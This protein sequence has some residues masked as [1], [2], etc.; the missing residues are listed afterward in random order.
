LLGAAKLNLAE[1]LRAEEASKPQKFSIY[2]T[3]R[4]GNN[5]PIEIGH[6]LDRAVR[7]MTR[8]NGGCT[9]MP[10]AKGA[11]KHRGT[12][13]LIVEDTI[14]IYSYLFDPEKFVTDFH[15]IVEL[16]HDYGYETKQDAV[17]AE[18]SGWSEEDQSYVS[19]AYLIPSE[20]YLRHQS[21]S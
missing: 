20:N 8:I 5:N 3:D 15:Y 19:E 14:V 7:V 13:K 2:I 16:L 18:F 9:R 21:P 4:D 17:I 10:A 12:R 11:W 1:L 6:W